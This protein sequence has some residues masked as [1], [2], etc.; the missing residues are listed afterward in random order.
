MA[1]GAREPHQKRAKRKAG[2]GIGQLGGLRLDQPF[3]KISKHEKR[4][5]RARARGPVIIAV[6]HRARDFGPPFGLGLRALAR[7]VTARR[8]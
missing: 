2:V 5:R 6:K 1:I 8:A 7:A 4:Y 3:E